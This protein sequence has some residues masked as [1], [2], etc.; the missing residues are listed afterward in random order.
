MITQA[1]PVVSRG[2]A[3][4]EAGDRRRRFV[5]VEALNIVEAGARL[6]WMATTHHA[7]ARVSI[8]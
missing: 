2:G 8:T 4:G 1:V 5:S 6:T 3:S 7:T